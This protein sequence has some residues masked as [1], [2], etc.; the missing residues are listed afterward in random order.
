MRRVRGFGR[1]ALLAAAIGLS[2]CATS[3][4]YGRDVETRALD[5]FVV[6][7]TT[8][9]DVMRALGT[10]RGRGEAYIPSYDARRDMLFYEF[11]ESD[12]QSVDLK[13]LLILLDG[14][15]YDGH[16]WFSSTGLIDETGL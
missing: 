15:R 4:E 10:P 9:D 1:A 11:V 8:R 3:I 13:F 14:D 2:G 7:K 12:M 6:G 16:F 5:G